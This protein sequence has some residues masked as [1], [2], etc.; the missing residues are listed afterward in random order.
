MIPPVFGA[1][2]SSE[3]AA[4]PEAKNPR[5]LRAA[6]EFEAI[7][8]R[9]MLK[10]LEKTTSM[11]SPSQTSTAQRTYGSMVVS[12]LADSI[13]SAGGLG[14]GEVIA[15]SLSGASS[16]R[17]PGKDPPAAPAPAVKSRK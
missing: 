5:L 3:P 8:L 17:P 13:S 14:L 9:Q 16:A 7:F 15:K 10:S 6:K 12:T 4:T 1:A 2:P 11:G